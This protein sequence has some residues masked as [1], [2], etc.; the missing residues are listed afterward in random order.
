M[1]QERR[2]RQYLCNNAESVCKSDDKMSKESAGITANLTALFNPKKET[3]EM[4]KIPIALQMYTLRDECEKDFAGTIRKVAEIGYPAVELA[5]RGSLSVQELSSL[6]ADNHLTIAGSH[7]GLDQLESDLPKVIQENLALG[8]RFVVVPYLSDEH[9]KTAADYKKTAETF[10]KI[11]ET[12]Q[13]SGLTLCYHNHDF[14]FQKMDTGEIGLDILFENSD[15]ALVKAEV[16]TYWVLK[17]GQDPVAFVRKH[18]GR[19]PLMHIK[20]MDM[21]DDSFAPVGTGKLP[22]DALIA[23]ASD[24]GTQYLI[25]E[26]DVCKGPAIDAVT[27]SYN[28][29]KAKGYA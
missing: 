24:I 4:P 21:A 9:R 5:G 2:G 14:E 6:L 26:Q 11:G 19:V 18:A 10:N 22:L 17:G 20:D 16:D 13:Q 28:N 3:Q 15:S 12:L 27:L 23:A 1:R 8:N 7:I 25:V 29:L